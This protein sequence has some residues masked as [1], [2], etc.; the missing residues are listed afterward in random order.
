[1]RCEESQAQSIGF[2]ISTHNRPGPVFYGK[3]RAHSTLLPTRVKM[4]NKLDGFY[5][6]KGFSLVKEILNFLVFIFE[7]IFLRIK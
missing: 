3:S 7:N 5:P 1:L 6:S 2:F 4:P